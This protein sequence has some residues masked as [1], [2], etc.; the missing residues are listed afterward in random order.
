MDRDAVKRPAYLHIELTDVDDAQLAEIVEY[1][2][3]GYPN[4][5]HGYDY[6]VGAERVPLKPDFGRSDGTRE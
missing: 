5:L 6:K 2:G 4:I 3:L 1:L